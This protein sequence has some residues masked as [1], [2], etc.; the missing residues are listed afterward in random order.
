MFTTDKMI[1]KLINA[2]KNPFII[3]KKIYLKI[4][5]YFQRLNYDE[6]FFT[7]SQN[8]K[9]QKLNLN[10][11]QGISN[12]N[13]IKNILNIP[14]REMSS[15][16]EIF[17]SSLSCKFE[18][19]FKKILEIGTF[20]ANNCFLLSQIFKNS[21]I[22]TIDLESYNEDFKNTYDRIDQ[23]KKFEDTRNSNLKKSKNIKFFEMNSIK[24]CNQNQKYDLIWIDGAH[25]YPLVCIDI[26][27]SIRLL[28]N[29]GLIMCDDVYINQVE[30][31]KMYK[32]IAAYEVLNELQKEKII[33]FELIYKRL[34]I[35]N[36]S[37]NR[38]RKFIAIVNKEQ[39]G[40]N[41]NEKI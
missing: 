18:N 23:I 3:P 33:S 31:D 25:G 9:F 29:E 8:E 12:L 10:R 40:K 14:D 4:Q 21:E 17:F 6:T 15:E 1:S 30:S 16:H 13:K 2:L 24:L 5:F 39:V 38:E 41:Y 32:S 28:N 11:N 35:K 34:D 7:K 22:H 27:N 37:S 19:K 36:N 26:I 20:D